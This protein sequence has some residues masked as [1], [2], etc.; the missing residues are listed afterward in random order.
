M[1]SAPL[2]RIF[3][4][5]ANAELINSKTGAWVSQDMGSAEVNDKPYTGGMFAKDE[6]AV[7]V[8]TTSMPVNEWKFIMDGEWH[9]IQNGERLVAKKGD[10]VFVP[11]GAAFTS[12]KNPFKAFFVTNR[13]PVVQVTKQD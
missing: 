2:V 10:V 13:G 8:E 5:V 12:L 4:D 9:M 7:D 11:K 6:H 1:S 3:S